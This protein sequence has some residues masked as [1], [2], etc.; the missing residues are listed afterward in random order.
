MGLEGKGSWPHSGCRGRTS[1]LEEAMM[2]ANRRRRSSAAEDGEDGVGGDA[3]RPAGHGLVER[4]R[5]S[6]RSFG[7]RRGGEAVAVAARALVGGD[8][9]VRSREREGAEG[10]RDG[11][12]D[13]G[14]WREVQGVEGSAWHPRV[15][16]AAS[17]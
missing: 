14:E 4:K 16:P 12:R 15:P 10:D 2:V 6:R 8:G 7:R 9:S 5:G 13:T 11:G 1:G 17:R 3:G